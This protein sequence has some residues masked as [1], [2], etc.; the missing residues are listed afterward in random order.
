MVSLGSPPPE[1]IN[2]Q[3]V[4]LHL[5]PHL[6]ANPCPTTQPIG[7]TGTLQGLL[8]GNPIAG[9]DGYILGWDQSR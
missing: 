5:P 8:L 3:V 7:F 9:F 2:C 6:R 1:L 4:P